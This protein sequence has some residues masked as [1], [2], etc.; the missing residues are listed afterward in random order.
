[1]TLEESYET[2]GDDLDE[3]EL[4]DVDFCFWCPDCLE[5]AEICRCGWERQPESADATRGAS[6]GE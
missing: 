6:E 1:M 4:S 5:P 3:L 2:I